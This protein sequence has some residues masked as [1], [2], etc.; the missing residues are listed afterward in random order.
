MIPAYIFCEVSAWKATEFT[1]ENSADIVTVY[2]HPK[3]SELFALGPVI[4]GSVEGFLDSLESC[5]D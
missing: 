1:I 2:Q 4:N 5:Y 3:N